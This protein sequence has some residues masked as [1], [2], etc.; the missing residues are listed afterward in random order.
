M[1]HKG[2]QRLHRGHFAFMRALI[3]GM[4][5]RTAWDRYLRGEGDPGDLRHVRRTILWIR[6]TFAAAA[7]RE[8]RPGTARLVLLDLERIKVRAPASLPTLAEF[9]AERGLEDFSED[10]QIEAYEEAYPAGATGRGSVSA[11]MRRGRLID[12]QLEALR[13][14][15]DLVVREPGPADGVEAWFHPLLAS[16]LQRAGLGTLD[17]LVAHMNHEGERWWRHVPAIGRHKADRIAAWLQAHAPR[18]GLQLQEHALVRR[19]ELTP[20]GR[21]E[22]VSAATALRPLEKLVLPTHLDGRNGQRRAAAGRARVGGSTDLDAVM[23]WIDAKAGTIGGSALNATQRGYR[24]EA[25]RLLLWAVLVRG[26]A[27][28]SLDAGDLR[29]YAAFLQQPPATWCGPRSHPRWSPKWR[30]LEGPLSASAHRQAVVVLHA[31]F[32]HLQHAGWID[33]NPVAEMKASGG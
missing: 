18:L 21:A 11:A 24:K 22:A 26:K 33:G 30:P 28:S 4:D 10:E 12:R 6:D 31:M 19:S 3:Q 14:L 5:E 16:R 9:A 25:E 7:R 8:R 1:Q 13:W 29:A 15:E 2:P 32:R 27:L 20:K 17:V 23:A